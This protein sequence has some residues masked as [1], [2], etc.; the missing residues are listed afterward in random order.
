MSVKVR[1]PRSGSKKRPF[2]RIVAINSDSRRDG[3]PLE[4]LGYYN[5][6]TTPGTLSIDNEKLEAWVGTGAELSDTVR[7]LLKKLGK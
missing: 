6:N 5:P 4:F 7:T 3:R 2:Y 1:M